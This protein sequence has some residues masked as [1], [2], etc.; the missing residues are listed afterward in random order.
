MSARCLQLRH[1]ICV[2]ADWDSGTAFLL[3]EQ[4]LLSRNA[5]TGTLPTSWG[6]YLPKVT[7]IDLSDNSLRGALPNGAP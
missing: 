3:L 1:S 5:L 7:V 2:T 4:M 6:S